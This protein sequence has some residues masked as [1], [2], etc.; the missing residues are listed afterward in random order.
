MSRR[1]C[2]CSTASETARS[3]WNS[4]LLLTP[5]AAVEYRDFDLGPADASVIAVAERLG[6]RRILMVDERDFGAVRSAD[7]E[8]FVLAAK[9]GI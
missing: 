3:G 1:N 6:V 2:G 5:G 4:S 7:G 8:A 9:K